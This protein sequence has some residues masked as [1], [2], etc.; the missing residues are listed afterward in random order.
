MRSRHKAGKQRMEPTM[1]KQKTTTSPRKKRRK[2]PTASALHHPSVLGE[3]VRGHD[4]ATHEVPNRSGH[5]GGPPR[6]INR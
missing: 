2:A 4:H 6:R 3:P 5:A 1:T